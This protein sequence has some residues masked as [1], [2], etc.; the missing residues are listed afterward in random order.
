MTRGVL[1]NCGCQSARPVDCLARRQR[2][3]GARIEPLSRCAPVLGNHSG[4]PETSTVAAKRGTNLRCGWGAGQ[5]ARSV[6]GA[7]RHHG[8]QLVQWLST[9]GDG[10][11]QVSA[12]THS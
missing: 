5:R 3:G 11:L 6:G 4:G 9:G 1:N 12:Q 8:A 7:G 2:S 10:Y